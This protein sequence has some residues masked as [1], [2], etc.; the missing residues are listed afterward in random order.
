MAIES[1]I[2]KTKNLSTYTL[3]GEISVNEIMSALESF[4]KEEPTEDVLW[5]LRQADFEGKISSTDLEKMARFIKKKSTQ[6]ARGKTALVAA[7]DLAFG[8]AREY[9]AIAEGEGVRN[10]IQVFRSMDRAIKWLESDEHST[11]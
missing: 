4:F 8:L 1:K 5:D 2:D 3:G 6:R 11:S 9:G 7:S 10:P